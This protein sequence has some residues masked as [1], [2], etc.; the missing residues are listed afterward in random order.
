MVNSVDCTPTA[1]PPRPVTPLGIL[2]DHLRSATQVL[3]HLVEL[4]PVEPHP[5]E[6]PPASLLTMHLRTALQLATGLDAYVENCTSQE[7]ADLRAIADRTR[8][9]FWSERFEDGTTT[10]P[11]EQ[12]MLSG[13][14]EGKTLQ[15]FARMIQARRILDIGMFTGY[16]A[17]AMAEALPEDGTLIACEVD[18]YVANLAQSLFER[19]PH[20]SKIQV[21]IGPALDTL[22]RLT[23]QG[24]CFDLVFI[25][26]DKR[27]Y[28][29]YYKQVMDG[30]LLAPN[31]IICVDNTLFQGQ[32]YLPPDHRSDNGRAIAQFNQLVAD[33]ARVEQVLLPLRDGLTLIRR[34]HQ[35]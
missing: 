14:V 16:S 6:P 11:L 25:D 29:A 12:E 19:S 17:L 33:D 35:G 2:I 21:A 20:G 15:L 26:A 28:M 31:G 27:E 34:C 1:V 13:H 10:R 18:P 4:H 5:V 23:Q 3:E 30:G 7:S 8:V 22:I 32:P 9:E 24:E